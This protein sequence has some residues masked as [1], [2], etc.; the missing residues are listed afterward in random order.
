MQEDENTEMG[1]GEEVR[2]GSI[3]IDQDIWLKA[4]A[5]TPHFHQVLQQFLR[6]SSPQ[7][8]WTAMGITDTMAPIP[9]IYDGLL[10]LLVDRKT[11]GTRPAAPDGTVSAPA[12]AGRAAA[13][14]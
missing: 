14:P 7:A 3:C 4:C 8:T 9:T 1:L 11:E 12:P 13:R 5:G 6:R 10:T 2:Q